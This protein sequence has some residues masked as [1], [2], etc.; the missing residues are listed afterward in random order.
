MY[1]TKISVHV[2]T[3]FKFVVLG[4]SLYGDQ[5]L[6]FLNSTYKV[7][8][9]YNIIIVIENLHISSFV[10]SLTNDSFRTPHLNERRMIVVLGSSKCD[11]SPALSLHANGYIWPQR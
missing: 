10:S 4:V 3:G 2:C 7:V 6:T 1:Q 11:M 9:C 8:F 5:F